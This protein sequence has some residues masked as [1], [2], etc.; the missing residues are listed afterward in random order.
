MSKVETLFITGNNLSSENFA[1]QFMKYSDL[2][3]IFQGNKHPYKDFKFFRNLLR[4]DKI[5]IESIKPNGLSVLFWIFIFLILKLLNKGVLLHWQG[6]D[7]TQVKRSTGIVLSKLLSCQSA[8][9]PWLCEELKTKGIIAHRFSI[10]PYGIPD[11]IPPLPKVF[12]VLVYLGN[13]KGK[14]YFY[15]KEGVEKLVREFKNVR[16]YIIGGNN[17]KVSLPHVHNLGWVHPSKMSE[18]YS[19]TTVLLRITKHDGLSHMVLEALGRGR[20]VIW[21]QKYSHCL[22]P[23]EFGE[24]TFYL[25]ELKKQKRLNINGVEF[26][27]NHFNELKC[28]QK[29]AEVLKINLKKE[30]IRK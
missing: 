16:F 28:V 24:I 27:R 12:T 5:L 23:K 17:L 11:K 29:Y 1:K 22:Y 13:F 15:G 25:E 18:I 3:I 14:E 20:Y 4:A 26:V 19:E 2:N 30:F 8:Q 7:V 9:A 10:P 21:S 6:T